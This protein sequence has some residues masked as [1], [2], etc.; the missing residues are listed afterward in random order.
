MINVER[1]ETSPPPSMAELITA[2]SPGEFDLD[3]KKSIKIIPS[4]MVCMTTN[5]HISPCKQ[6]TDLKAFVHPRNQIYNK[7]QSRQNEVN[8]K[9]STDKNLRSNKNSKPINRGGWGGNNR[10]LQQSSQRFGPHPASHYNWKKGYRSGHP[11]PSPQTQA[12]LKI[13]N[14]QG[15]QAGLRYLKPCL[16]IP[17]NKEATADTSAESKSLP[18]DCA[19]EES[20]M[21]DVGVADNFSKPYGKYLYLS[22]DNKNYSF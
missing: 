20:I 7:C 5:H 9:H 22:N 19:L 15:T 11:R 21:R 18:P 13:T 6:V 14:K 12:W 2:V 16:N 4:S 3:W 17:A 10:L 8:G 1:D